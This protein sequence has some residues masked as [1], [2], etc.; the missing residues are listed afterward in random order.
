MA[1]QVADGV[2]IPWEIEH[3][4]DESLLYMRIHRSYFRDG[5]LIPGAFKDHGGGMST[6][7]E[8]YS[9]PTDTHQRA[10]TPKDNAVIAMMA[11]DVRA[12]PGLV[13]SH[14]P[15]PE[16]RAHT[17]VIGE[18]TTEVRVRLLRVYRIILPIEPA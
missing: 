2:N 17:D 18:K 3:I 1:P 5:K 12:V 15:I 16:N 9:S 6:D 14:S 13:I 11:G 8:K 7:W 4:P 10:R